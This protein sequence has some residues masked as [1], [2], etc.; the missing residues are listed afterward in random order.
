MSTDYVLGVTADLAR[1]QLDHLAELFDRTSRQTLGDVGVRP[2]DRCL[3]VGA[4]RGSVANWMAEQ[5]GPTGSVVAIDVD[6]DHVAG[7]PGVT[8]LHHDVNDGVPPGGPF[9]VIHARLVLMHLS[10]RAEILRTLTD[11]LAPGGRI[12]LGE[13][14]VCGT[15][16]HEVMSAP[17]PGDTDLFNRVLD[18]MLNVAGRSAGIHYEWYQEVGPR[19]AAAG[20]EDVRG[21][22]HAA[23]AVGGT[24]GSVLYGNYV[25]QVRPLLLDAGLTDDE[26]TRFVEL[27]YDPAFRVWCLPLIYTS[28]RRPPA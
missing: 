17:G 15:R 24:P 13:S 9:D 23:T 10:R 7:T 5:A 14:T 21:T 11:A 8:V 4:G 18:V 25:R 2:G 20:L 19:L 6:T 3:E 16:P 26:L 22:T 1:E 27:A 28:G 12:V